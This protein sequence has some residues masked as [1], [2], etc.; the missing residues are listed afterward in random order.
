MNTETRSIQYPDQPG[1]CQEVIAHVG[2]MMR[3]LLR[4]RPI[5]FGFHWRGI[6]RALLSGRSAEEPAAESL[7]TVDHE[8]PFVSAQWKWQFACAIEFRPSWNGRADLGRAVPGAILH[9]PHR[10]IRV[11]G[12]CGVHV[13]LPWSSRPSTSNETPMLILLWFLTIYIQIFTARWE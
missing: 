11:A 2:G 9:G 13:R 1:S 6:C 10:G 8:Q 4:H 3:A 7:R 12:A 5:Y